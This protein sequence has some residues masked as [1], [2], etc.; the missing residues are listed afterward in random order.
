MYS[1]KITI[2]ELNWKIL[3]D[4]LFIINKI[5]VTVRIKQKASLP[6]N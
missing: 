4:I 3:D 5:Y 6:I 2:N 1:L